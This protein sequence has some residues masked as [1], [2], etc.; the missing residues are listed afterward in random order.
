MSVKVTLE[1][2]AERTKISRRFLESIE[3]GKYDD[4]PGGVF[5]TSY[6]RQYAAETGYD[7]EEILRDYRERTEEPAAPKPVVREEP[8]VGSSRWVKFLL[9]G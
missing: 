6:I 4:L 2:I 3:Q 7:A 9:F 5:A 8:V 1:A